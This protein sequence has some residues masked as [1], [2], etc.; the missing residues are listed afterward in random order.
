MTKQG[1]FLPFFHPTSKDYVGLWVW[2]ED[3]KYS[4]SFLLATCIICVF[5]SLAYKT[6]VVAHN[7][8]FFDEKDVG[9]MIYKE[10]C[11]MFHKLPKQL[12][13]KKD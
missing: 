2:K 5:S 1:T 10:I 3:N 6:E 13:Q 7:S 4:S 11:T 9:E 12:S 8:S